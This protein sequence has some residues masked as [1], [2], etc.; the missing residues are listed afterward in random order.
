M[1]KKKLNTLNK[2]LVVVSAVLIIALIASYSLKG[3]T[4]S[5]TTINNNINN[6]V[7]DIEYF[8]GVVEKSYN[9]NEASKYEISAS[10]KSGTLQMQIV[11]PN[12]NTVDNVAFSKGEHQEIMGNRELA[13]GK[14]KFLLKGFFLKDTH[15]EIK[16]E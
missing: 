4:Y 10:I 15:I 16:F 8:Y 11:D 2:F 1:R 5:S 3:I 9:F 7:M 13:K 6:R 12:G 14:Y